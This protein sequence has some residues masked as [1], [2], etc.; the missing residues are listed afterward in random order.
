MTR[1]DKTGSRQRDGVCRVESRHAGWV[2]WNLR[3]GTQVVDDGVG[4]SGSG[5]QHF[6]LMD[7]EIKD[8]ERDVPQGS[9]ARK[10]QGKIW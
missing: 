4:A 6:G 5:K 1:Q 9:Q 3:L 2:A 8:G 10:G 7:D